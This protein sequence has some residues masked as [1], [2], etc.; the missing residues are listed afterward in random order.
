MNYT[1]DKIVDTDNAEFRDAY[2]LL[3]Y[4]HQ[5]VFLTGKAG[6]GKSTFL[7]YT[8][9]NT[10][11][12]YVVLAP[13][14]IAAINAGGSTIH[15]FFK[16]SFRPILPDD[17]DLSVQNKRIYDLLKYNKT[18]RREINAA[19]RQIENSGCPMLGCILTKVDVNSLSSK[20]YYNRSYRSHYYS[21]YYKKDKDKRK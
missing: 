13:T 11:K 16:M 7:R 10:R 9:E 14:G 18:H 15:S 1:P 8:C 4:T 12:K 17:P 21:N 5:S 19:Q 2:A 20:H 6:T 3:Q